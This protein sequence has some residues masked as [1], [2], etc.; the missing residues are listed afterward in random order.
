[1]INYTKP[2]MDIW[3]GRIDDDKNYNAFRWHQWVKPLN[4]MDETIYLDSN[5]AGVYQIDDKGKIV[6]IISKKGLILDNNYLN[7]SLEKTN[8]LFDELFDLEELC[9]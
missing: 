1:M 9:K 7:N 5:Q 6:S 4:L 3:T 2:N 8:E